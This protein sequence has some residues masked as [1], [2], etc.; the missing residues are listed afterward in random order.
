MR[1]SQLFL[2]NIAQAERAIAQRSTKECVDALD[3]GF[4]D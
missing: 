1:G 4:R 2:V 3:A